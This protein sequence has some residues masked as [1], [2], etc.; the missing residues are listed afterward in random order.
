V[1]GGP[2]PFSSGRADHTA[3]NTLEYFVLF[4]VLALAAHAV[5]AESRVMLGVDLFF[6]SRLVYIPVY[7]AGIAYA[8]AAVQAVSIVSLAMM[9]LALI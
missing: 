8:R 3:K 2:R 4:A 1:A 6:W 7:Y 9:V 5:G